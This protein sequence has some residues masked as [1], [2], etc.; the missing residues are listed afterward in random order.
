MNF[1]LRLKFS[2]KIILGISGIM[3]FMALVLTPSVSQMAASALVKESKKR[4]LALAGGLAVRAVDP[5]LTMD[6]LQL[7]NIVHDVQNMGGAIVYAFILD[8]KKQ[9]LAHTFQKGF[10]IDLVSANNIDNSKPSQ[11]QL[12]DTGRE[13]IYDFAAPIVIGESRVGT[14]R[15][16]LSRKIIQQEVNRLI[17]TIV[18]LSAGT[19]L[20]A[21]LIG[22][23]FGRWVTTRLGILKKS[24]EEM[25]EGDLDN[26]TGPSLKRNCWEIMNC[27]LKEK[28]PAYGDSRRRCWY[29]AGTMCEQCDH[30]AYPAKLKSC[31]TCPVYQENVGDEIQDLAE[32]FDVMALN[33]KT[34]ITEI[35]NYQA[36]LV[37]SQKMDSIGQMAAGVAHE[38]NTPLGIILGY[39]QLLQD[40]ID[41]KDS[42][43]EEL[44]VIERQAKVCRK[45]VA[46]LLNFSRQTETAKREMSINNS[47]LETIALVEHT[48][49]MSKVLLK[50]DLEEG[51][52]N[53]VG[54][55]D[56]LKQVWINF[57]NNARDAM[58][59]G[60]II[61]VKSRMDTGKNR[62]VISVADT[63]PGISEENMKKIFDP[64][65]T[66]KSVGKGTGLGLSVS[67][68]IIEDHSGTIQAQSP[69]PSDLNMT[70]FGDIEPI[71]PG[72][73]FV[74]EIPV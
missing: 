50:T 55:P 47:L 69:L 49:S 30:A 66:T 45:I 11:I 31:K 64:F 4:G 52:D 13:F 59:G 25:L 28:C 62:M 2:T 53:I 48:F 16:G 58:S 27:T 9:V 72:T 18:G 60:G 34:H 57:F 7:K 73:V 65:F 32:T 54:D 67:F 26:Q 70:D 5:M 44:Q 46:D 23:L 74:V 20:L 39:T 43:M 38:I 36:Q 37:Q 22:A 3:V 12:L 24:V 21:I 56:K 8:S 29:V 19:L 6:L 15:I 41:P 17:L 68:G 42:M 71:G 33:L 10:P 35:K 40:D 14:G 63:G 61:L 51:N 1:F